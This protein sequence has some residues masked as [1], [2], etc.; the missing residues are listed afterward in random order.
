MRVRGNINFCMLPLTD[1]TVMIQFEPEVTARL[2]IDWRVKAG[3]LGGSVAASTGG[4]TFVVVELIWNW[5]KER[6]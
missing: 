6:R 3:G 4:G 1:E 2:S 5:T